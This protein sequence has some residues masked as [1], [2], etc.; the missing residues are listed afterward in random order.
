MIDRFGV[1]GRLLLAFFGISAFA[2]LAAVAAMY[3]FLKVGEALDRITQDRVPATVASQRLSRQA[4]RIAA[5]APALL[6]VDS[7]AEHER[8]SKK[9][10]TELERL[11]E[12]LR[13]LRGRDVDPAS[14]ILIENLVERLGTNLTI[15][16]TMMINNLVLVERTRE[17]L[18]KLRFTDIAFGRLIAPGLLVMNAKLADLREALDVRK[19]I[20]I[21]RPGEI[22]DLVE[23]IVSL[24]P[25]Q[26][27]QAEVSAINDK[28]ITAASADSL[29][30][31]GVLVFPLR[32][33]LDA[34][35]ESLASVAPE[36]GAQLG[37][38]LEKYREFVDGADSIVGARASELRHLA[39][40]QTLL[41]ENVEISR[42]LTEAVDRL[43]ASAI[44]DIGDANLEAL[45]VQRVSTGVLI[46]VVALSVISSILI[47]WLYVGRNLIA[48]LTAMSGSMLAI[49]GGRLDTSIPAAGSD[50]IGRA[51]CRERV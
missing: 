21:Q 43:V 23:P 4:E 8:M 31:L 6:T 10:S 37:T 2:V 18:H 50:E 27:A 19:A 42:Q 40:M 13:A 22:V 46:A 24:A 45:S 47:V 51:S 26:R 1:R 38:H 20:G 39:L 44:R 48:R 36:L 11:D 29:T 7:A 17:L 34:L 5:A 15:V 25:L 49:A 12:L 32:R 14:L 16:D 3:S 9:I 35:E 33:S 28:L 30:D 41:N